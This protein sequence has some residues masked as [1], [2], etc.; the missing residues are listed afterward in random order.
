MRRWTGYGPS[1]SISEDAFTTS[2]LPAAAKDP[3]GW[4]FSENGLGSSRDRSQKPPVNWKINSPVK[5]LFFEQGARLT[6]SPTPARP[7]Y[8]TDD[9]PEI[10]VFGLKP[11]Q[12]LKQPAWIEAILKDRHL[13]WPIKRVEFF[14]E[15][16]PSS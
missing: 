4:G 7:E 15:G 8:H 5:W 13:L 6:G 14:I 2:N 1:L 16:N 11:D 10:E 9:T 12:V 3:V